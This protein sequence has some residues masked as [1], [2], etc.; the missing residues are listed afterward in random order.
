LKINKLKTLIKIKYSRPID[1]RILSVTITRQH[2][3]QYFV[4]INVS[5]S[6]IIQKP[7][8]GNSVGIDL[9]LKDCYTI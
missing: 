3:S 2:N 8:T 7:K 6:I 5:K 4:S 9:G 1:V